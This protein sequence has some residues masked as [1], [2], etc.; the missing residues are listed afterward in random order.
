MQ[1]IQKTPETQ[2]LLKNLEYLQEKDHKSKKSLHFL[3]ECKNKNI[4]PKFC[5]LNKRITSKLTPN[6]KIKIERRTLEKAIEDQKLK[7]ETL[8]KKISNIIES[9][10][11]HFDQTYITKKFDEIS[12]KV[13]QNQAFYDKKRNEKLKKLENSKPHEPIRVEILNKTEIVIPNDVHDIISLGL[14]FNIGGVPRQNHI[15]KEFKLLIDKIL[16]F[17]DSSNIQTIDKHRFR[18]NLFLLFDDINKCRIDNN[19]AF[20]IRRFI[21]E[22]PEIRILQVDKSPNIAIWSKREYHQKMKKFF[23]E[24]KFESIPS[25]PLNTDIQFYQKIKKPFLECLPRT[26]HKHFKE[27]HKLKYA[28]ELV[29]AHKEGHPLRIISSSFETLTS[30]AEKTLMKY[31]TPLMKHCKYS[32][33]STKVFKENFV[34]DKI[35]TLK[36][37]NFAHLT[38]NQCTHQFL[39]KKLSN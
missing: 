33:G 15:I 10:S 5:R 29:K 21:R 4:I 14:R 36:I 1:N 23:E 30:K 16:K 17:S 19:Y 2:P 3:T 9:L 7:I 18:S 34:N 32:V 6:E 8:S 39:Q 20:I 26:E 12:K 37:T 27:I 13:R 24:E 31:L 11:Y 28:Y 22:N 35:K 38:S 25:D